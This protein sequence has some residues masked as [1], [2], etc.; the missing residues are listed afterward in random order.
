MGHKL[1]RW[2]GYIEFSLSSLE[3]ARISLITTISTM[4]WTSYIPIAILDEVQSTHGDSHMIIISGSKH[5]QLIR[6]SN[7]I[8]TINLGVAKNHITNRAKIS[9]VIQMSQNAFTRFL[10]YKGTNKNIF[11]ILKTRFKGFWIFKT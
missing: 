2:K 5:I 3:M 11:K 7:I 9:L 10:D 6:V 1:I 4:V 8:F